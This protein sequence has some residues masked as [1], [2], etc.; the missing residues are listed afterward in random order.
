[1]T[2]EIPNALKIKVCGMRNPDNMTA[3]AALGIDYMGFIFHPKSPRFISKTDKA[4]IQQFA[5]VKKVGVFVNAELPYIAQLTQE[6]GL[7]ALQLHGKETPQYL[8]DLRRVISD[9]LPL[10]T[11][12]IKAFSVDETFDFSLVEPYLEWADYFLFDTKSPQG[13]GAGIKFDWAILERYPFNKPFFLAGGI[14]AGDAETVLR[15]KNRLPQLYALDL[16]SKFEKEPALKDT[17]L[18]G[19]FLSQLRTQNV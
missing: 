15:L 16:N 4:A 14:H 2:I 3:V 13:G 11:Q 7:N 17:E 6:L 8:R 9:I 5:A 10:E 12:I 19:A 1:M 18:L